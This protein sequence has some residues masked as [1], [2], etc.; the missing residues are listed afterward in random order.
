MA[1]VVIL[2]L[3]HAWRLASSA[4]R[5][6]RMGISGTAKNPIEYH[7]QSRTRWRSVASPGILLRPVSAIRG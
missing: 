4:P 5:I 3:L 2:I 1:P 6:C 7:P